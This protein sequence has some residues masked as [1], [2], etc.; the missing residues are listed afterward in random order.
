M[1]LVNLLEGSGSFRE[2]WHHQGWVHE[3]VSS[4]ASF[5]LTLLSFL[6]MR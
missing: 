3:D 6:S 1:Q 2:A 4:P 5:W